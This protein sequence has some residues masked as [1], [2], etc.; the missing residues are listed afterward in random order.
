MNFMTGVVIRPDVVKLGVEKAINEYARYR[1]KHVMTI[2]CS[3]D[4][5]A[6]YINKIGF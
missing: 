4:L 5:I 6:K 2:K 3:F 1:Y